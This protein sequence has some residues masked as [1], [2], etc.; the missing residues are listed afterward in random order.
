[1]DDALAEAMAEAEE[2]AFNFKASAMAEASAEAMSPDQVPHGCSPV[3]EGEGEGEEERQE[4]ASNLE[5]VGRPQA[6]H[7]VH[8]PVGSFSSGIPSTPGR[9]FVQFDTSRRNQE[10]LDVQPMEESEEDECPQSTEGAQ[11]EANHA[12]RSTA[13]PTARKKMK[14]LPKG[15]V[16]STSP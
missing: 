8:H 1:M 13:K 12:A 3:G 7:S 5:E 10:Q 14:A 16:I 11:L 4:D 2:E 15:K 6:E 9:G